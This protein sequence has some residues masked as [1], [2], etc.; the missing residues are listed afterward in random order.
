M[1]NLVLSNI[2]QWANANLGIVVA[3]L[4]GLVTIIFR[5]ANAANN[6]RKQIDN[7]NKQM[8]RPY[9]KVK[10][11]LKVKDEEG[12]SI[13][14]WFYRKGTD[15]IADYYEPDKITYIDDE[16]KT[17]YYYYKI[18][19]ENIGVGVATNFM[20]AQIDDKNELKKVSK[21]KNGIK[22]NIYSINDFKV[23]ETRNMNLCFRIK[24]PID[25]KLAIGYFKVMMCYTDINENQ[26]ISF[27]SINAVKGSC[28]QYNEGGHKFARMLKDSK[29]KAR[30]VK[31]FYKK[32]YF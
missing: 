2:L 8:H 27:L 29:I 3:I 6:A 17:R 4:V 23:K 1:D 19:L 20:L 10:D 18:S 16:T 7:Q 31:K 25:E 11:F 12:K 28:R 14:Y 32:T 13:E 9:L 21:V 22:G 26:Y 5:N 15:F 24:G 30:D